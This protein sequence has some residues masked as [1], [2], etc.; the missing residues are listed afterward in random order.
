M[1][2]TI[3][4]TLCT[5]MLTGI[6]AGCAAIPE[7]AL[8]EAAVLIEQ[9]D[10]EETDEP[11]E[12][13]ETRIRKMTE[14]P[15]KSEAE[16]AVKEEK[17]ELAQKPETKTVVTQAPKQEEKVDPKETP[18]PQETKKPA[19]TATLEIELP[20]QPESPKPETPEATETPKP[21]EPAKPKPTPQPE[22]PTPAPTAEPSPEPTP[23]PTPVPTPEPTPEPQPEMEVMGGGFNKAVLAGVNEIRAQNGNALL[24]LDS[25]LC[26]KALAHAKEMAARGEIFHA[27]GG[28]ESVS[29]DTGSGKSIGIRSAAHATGLALDADRSRLGVGSVKIGDRQYTCV[30]AP[31]D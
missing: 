17:E 9:S 3:L 19:A 6:F 25:G 7:S 21:A 2:K 18:K 28:A 22:K 23:E 20:K 30:F 10:P 24:T 4:V 13:P 12:N 8:E 1:K 31:R 11:Q 14:L 16:E 15:S 29:N 5:V 26:K 27:C